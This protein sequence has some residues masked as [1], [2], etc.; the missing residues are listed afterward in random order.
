MPENKPNTPPPFSELNAIANAPAADKTALIEAFK[1]HHPDHT[2]WLEALEQAPQAPTEQGRFPEIPGYEISRLIGS[3]ANGSVW[4]AS[5]SSGQTVAIKTPNIWLTDDQITRFKHEARLLARLDHKHIARVLDVGD[6]ATAQGKLPFLGLEYI[7]GQTIDQYI[8]DQQLSAHETV[9]LF[10][11]VLDAVQYAHQKSVIHRDIKP[12]NIVV[13]QQ[14]VPQLLDFGIATL[15]ADATRAMTQLTRT[16]EI[17]GTLAY[18]SPEQITAADDLDSRSDIYACG[19][20]LYELIS[21]QLPYQVDASRFFSAINVILNDAPKKITTCTPGIDPSLAA[22]IHHAIEKKPEQRFQTALGMAN[23]LQ[24]WLNGDPI[25]SQQLSQWYW[26]RQAARKHKALVTGAAL[27]FIGLVTGLVFAV[28]FALKEQ[29]ARALA[30]E[31][32]ES[33][34]QVVRFINDLFVNADP[35]NNL[36]EAITVKQ[37]IEGARYSV[38]Q[39][40]AEDAGVE[41]QIRLVLGNV[42]DAI[43]LYPS[44]IS[45]YDKGLGRLNEQNELYFELATQRLSSLTS[46]SEFL[47]VQTTIE[48]LINDIDKANLTGQQR[49]Q[50]NNR[51]LFEQ[52]TY[53]STNSQTDEALKVLQQ[54]QQQPNLSFQERLEV[55]KN[56]GYIHRDQGELDQA[57]TVFQRLLEDAETEYGENHPITLDLVQ[58]VALTLRQQNSIDEALNLYERLVAGMEK[59]YGPT[60]LSTLLARINQA[61]AHMYAGAFDVADEMTAELLPLMIEHVGPMHQYTL[62]LRNIRGGA[63]DNVGKW[64]EALALYAETLDLFLQSDSKDNFNTIN[65]P[66]NMA[67]I[68]YKQERYAQ[69]DQ[70]YLHNRPLC[71]QQLTRSHPLCVIMADSHAAVN[72]ELGQYEQAAELLAYSNPALIET[73]GESH[74]RVAASNKR[75]ALLEE[76][77]GK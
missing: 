2:A 29:Q 62:T 21:G 49:Q 35:T 3:G 30:D 34:R 39:D 33:N 27:A 69:A 47:A 50:F 10:L 45:Q 54:L 16:G 11:P 73:F 18:M 72:I 12:E 59:N 36:G 46:N 61:T 66:H 48:Q 38:D 8:H 24:A 14:G 17:V 40:L 76:R 71:E 70:L 9:A 28:S 57:L 44:A 58:E 74:P 64:D 60:S 25:Q 13:N 19:V 41:A 53:L 31:Q 1:T 4:Q 43:E 20:V 65:I 75:L 5:D 15:D 68:Y 51:I 77:R 63:L 67:V 37:V 22:V 55:D 7:A 32:A 6:Y 42:F 52:A 26:L 56:L 23:D